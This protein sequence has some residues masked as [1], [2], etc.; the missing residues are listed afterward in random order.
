MCSSLVCQVLMDNF[1]YSVEINWEISM[2][3]MPIIISIFEND[4][5]FKMLTS[6]SIKWLSSYASFLVTHSLYL[7]SLQTQEFKR[8]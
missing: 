1:S 3:S 8:V 2:V 7:D 6:L 5:L 4:I